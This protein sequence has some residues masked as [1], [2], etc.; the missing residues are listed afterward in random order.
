MKK[1]KAGIV[2]STGVVGQQFVVALQ[3][4]PWFE[5][6]RLAASERS[7][8]R[9]Y[10]AALKD[11][12]TGAMRWYCEQLPKE[13]I[14]ELEVEDAAQLD[15]SNL[16]IVFSGVESEIA[17]KLE[18]DYA[19]TTPVIS[20]AAAFRYEEDTP[21][22]MPGVN[23]EHIELLKEQQRRR[24]WSGF[25]APTAN[26][27]A[28]GLVITLKPIQDAFGIERVIMTSMQAASGAGRS[29]GVLTL[30]IIDNLIPFIPKEEEKVQMETVKILGQFSG[31]KITPAD[32]K[33]SSTC[34]RI[35][36]RDGHTE[37]VSV[38]TGRECSVDEVKEAM[39]KFNGEAK[40]AGL[41]SAPDEMIVIA[42]D[43]YRP[44][45]RLDR[46]NYNG[47]AT[48]VGR[49]RRDEALERGVKYVLVSHNTRMGASKGAVLLAELLYKKG[50]V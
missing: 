11:S 3:D 41:P 2:G 22:L 23:D 38:S 4:H 48:T 8:H 30:D 47:M 40:K 13:E 27:T 50:F 34:T 29:P 12:K 25:I 26:C 24:N 33:V 16:D 21:I 20:T 1:L 39:R 17:L 31:V 28:T 46:D 10:G 36:V 5:I 37:S 35:N 14:L 32:M 43:P 19:R 45:P 6:E 15:S 9:N 49:I 18:P 42:E 7:A 44:Q